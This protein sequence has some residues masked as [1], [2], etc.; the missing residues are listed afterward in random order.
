MV[1]GAQK[2]G[3]QGCSSSWFEAEIATMPT[4]SALI[5]GLLA[6]AIAAFAY[7]L[8]RGLADA[9]KSAKHS[10]AKDQGF[11]E[12]GAAWVLQTVRSLQAQ[13]A[14][15]PDIIGALNPTNDPRVARTLHD[16]RGPHMFIPH[17][18]LAV[19]EAA[20]LSCRN[21]PRIKTTHQVLLVAKQSMKTITRYGD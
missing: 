9:E 2:I 15:W 12:G 13:D 4:L 5:Y 19:I 7:T 16:L 21:D 3:S 10:D 1:P 18:A 11:A 17:T 8:W 20:C 14:Q 6:V